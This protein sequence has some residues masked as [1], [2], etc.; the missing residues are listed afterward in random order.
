[1]AIQA[2][3]DS[4]WSTV[5][6]AV[7]RNLLTIVAINHT[8]AC[9]W[10][11]VGRASEGMGRT[12]ISQ[13]GLE[14]KE[15][16]QQYLVSLHWSLAQFTPGTTQ[17]VPETTFELIFADL[18][19]IFG[20]V[21]FTCFISSITSLM[22]AVWAVNR[23]RTTQDWLLKKFLRQCKVSSG[24]FSRIT[25]YTDLVV[26][27]QQKTLHPSK[28]QFLNLLSGP[29]HIE[30]QTELYSPRLYMHP[31]FKAYGEACMSAVRELCFKALVDH[32][33][34]KTDS[35]FHRAV[36]AHNM[37]F[38]AR[39]CAVYYFISSKIPDKR[40]IVKLDKDQWCCEATLWLR[41][42]HCGEMKALTESDIVA[43]N[44]AK[45]R[46]VTAGHY[47]AFLAAKAYAE[48]FWRRLQ[49]IGATEDREVSDV[50][51]RLMD[52]IWSHDGRLL[53]S[54]ETGNEG[55]NEINEAHIIEAQ[56][57]DWEEPDKG[58]ADP[59]RKP[60][61]HPADEG[62]RRK[63]RRQSTSSL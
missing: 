38:I 30:L 21:I 40:K 53:N 23:H 34:A 46:E 45:F 8:L 13:S 55:D 41:W 62:T 44:G 28:V 29:L 19:L 4:E 51:F 27:R 57:M 63:E 16:F 18:M 42:V 37:Y 36:E 35:I 11:A 58:E 14:D 1:M 12:W 24:L 22:Q 26:E 10:F 39:G 32:S 3:I 61:K 6:I 54:G 2:L 20:M 15:M 59:G 33:F 49:E 31:F 5:S 48:Q 9:C 7:C 47:E 60:S 52:N 43:L 17:I 50:D 25:R 56:L